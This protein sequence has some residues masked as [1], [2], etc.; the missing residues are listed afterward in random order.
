MREGEAAEQIYYGVASVSL[1]G[2]EPSR[3]GRDANIRRTRI[4]IAA[5]KPSGECSEGGAA[6]HI[7]R[8]R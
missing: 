1:R 5:F 3:L 4:A 6:S 8:G 2:A 7:V